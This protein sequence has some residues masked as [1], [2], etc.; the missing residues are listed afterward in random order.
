MSIRC[1]LNARQDNG[2][3][4]RDFS[5]RSRPNIGVNRLLCMQRRIAAAVCGARGA[6]APNLARTRCPSVASIDTS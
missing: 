5:N 6:A 3:R 4:W 2:A 1:Q